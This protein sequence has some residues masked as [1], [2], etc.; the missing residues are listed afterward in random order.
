MSRTCGC[1]DCQTSRAQ[2]KDFRQSAGTPDEEVARYKSVRRKKK[3][4]VHTYERRIIGRENKVRRFKS[5]RGDRWIT[6]EYVG[7]KIQFVCTGCG[8]KRG[9]SWGRRIW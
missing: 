2:R 1:D 3:M 8:N 5:F 9:S 6:S 4:H 7:N